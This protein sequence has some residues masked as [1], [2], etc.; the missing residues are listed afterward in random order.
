MNRAQLKVSSASPR[1]QSSR[2]EQERHGTAPHYQLPPLTLRENLKLN[3]SPTHTRNKV[4]FHLRKDSH[5]PRIPFHLLIYPLQ[6]RKQSSLPGHT[7]PFKIDTSEFQADMNIPCPT[8]LTPY[9]PPN[10][11]QKLLN[12]TLSNRKDHLSG[13]ATR[14]R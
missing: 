9:I 3:Q 10:A 5:L 6:A 8:L 11:Q 7:P 12:P 14:P 13:S 4:H 1:R 2:T